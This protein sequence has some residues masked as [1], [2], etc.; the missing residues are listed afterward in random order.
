M[1]LLELVIDPTCSIVLERQP[2]EYDIMKRKP[3]DPNEKLL[4]SKMLFKSILQ[5]VIIFGASFGT[6]FA[7]LSKY[8][9]NASLARAMGLT[10]ILMANI[11][12]VQ[13]NSSD[14]ELA[15]KSVKRLAKD[16][17]MW[18]VSL[19]TIAGL[20]LI[21]YTP[22]NVFLKLSPL[23]LKQFGV[24]IFI[25]IISVSWYEIVKVVKATN[26]NHKTV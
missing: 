20:L 19:G 22:I 8:P 17:V 5:G 11:L 2:A 25:S 6:Y 4:T 1:V 12:L 13:V 9:D 3:R 10:I 26:K 18:G 15:I 7:F 21:L 23:S 14:S 24:A 16:K